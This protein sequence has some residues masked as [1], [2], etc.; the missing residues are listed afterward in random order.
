MKIITPE[1]V[2]ENMIDG[3]RRRKMHIVVPNLW[4]GYLWLEK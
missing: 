3:I 2:A 4:S 1:V